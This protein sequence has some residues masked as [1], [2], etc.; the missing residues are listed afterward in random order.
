M[1]IETLFEK[2]LWHSRL[3][4]LVPVAASLVVSFGMF[5][6]STMD[7]ATLVGH[8]LHLIFALGLYELFVSRIEIAE[9]SEL[10]SRLLLIRSRRRGDDPAHDLLFPPRCARGAYSKR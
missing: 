10:A 8:I 4:V 1:R 3:V 5:Y 2:V 9:G 7:V 6:V